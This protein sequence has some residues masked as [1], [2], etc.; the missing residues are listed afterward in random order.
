MSESDDFDP[1]TVDLADG[2]TVRLAEITD[3]RVL[4]HRLT[5]HEIA[6]DMLAADI[7]LFATSPVVDLGRSG[8]VLAVQGDDDDDFELR[9]ADPADFHGVAIALPTGALRD[10]SP[11]DLIGIEMRDLECRLV[12]AE[13]GT[14]PEDLAARID[15][16]VGDSAVLAHALVME[17]F[18]ADETLCTEPSPPLSELLSDAG[19]EVQDALVARAGFDFG[20]FLLRTAVDMVAEAYDLHED[21]ALAVQGFRML[22]DMTPRLDREHAELDDF[23]FGALGSSAAADAAWDLVR[24]VDM[25]EVRRAALLLAHGPRRVRSAGHWLA[26]RATDR[27]GLLEEAENHYEQALSANSGFV[28]ALRDLAWLAADRSD[29]VRC[30]SLFERAFDGA[31]EAWADAHDLFAAV[32]AMAPRPHPELGRNDRCWCGSGRK[33]KVC[34]LGRSEATEVQRA[35]FLYLRAEIFATQYAELGGWLEEFPPDAALFEGGALD[36]YSRRRDGLFTDEDR[37]LLDTWGDVPRAVYEVVEANDDGAKLRDLRTDD[38]QQV[39]GEELDTAV[40]DVIT[41]RALPVGEN[42]H[43]F[44]WYPVTDETADDIIECLDEE[45][46][47]GILEVLG[48]EAQRES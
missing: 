19:F 28:L 8:M 30:R 29:I 14:A 13:A 33:Y 18:A 25:D 22:V 27:M 5:A 41:A 39:L 21:E 43:L 12:S 38:V 7:D 48:A 15:A 10:R 23:V 44:D 17:L 37:R 11:G 4:T 45:D 40:G 9:D 1:L 24:G 16:V 6:A 2:R 20:D 36:E 46:D 35:A 31:D 42:L 34:H 47:F 26:G 32:A 3:G